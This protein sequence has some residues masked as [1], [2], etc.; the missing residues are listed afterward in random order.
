M[1]TGLKIAFVVFAGLVIVFVLIFLGILPGRRQP[2]PPEVTLEFWGF[3]DP[4]PVWLSLISSY[5]EENTH[6]DI[7]YTEIDEET[8]E[9]TLVNK[10]AEGKGPDIF[11]LKNAWIE[12]HR[13]K[14]YPLP[15]DIFVFYP[16]DFRRIFVDIA[17]QD[18]IT[19]GDD[20]IG[21]PLFVDTPALFYNKDV[22]NSHGIA[23]PPTTWDDVVLTSKTLTELTPV[24]DVVRGG[25][26]LGSATNIERVL[27]VL[28]SL[29]FQSGDAIIQ[30]D[31]VDLSQSG[32][33]ALIFYTSFADPTKSH[34]SWNIRLKNSHDALAEGSAAMTIGLARDIGTI[35]AKNPHLNLGVTKLPQQAGARNHVVYGSY[36]FPTVSNASR[37]PEEAWAF[38]SYVGS[39]G[40]SKSYTGASG[41]VP[42]RRDLLEEGTPSPELD[43]FYS[44]ALIARSWAV[45][46]EKATESLIR[47]MVESVILKTATANRALNTFKQKLQLIMAR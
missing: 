31:E 32:E 27:E 21:M 42:A 4:E 43:V 44:Q 35:R 46:D 2:P 45:P 19:E 5:T 29:I 9:E 18:L 38:L 11:M 30:G 34:Y 3:G 14:I 15:Q 7:N 6:V 1:N 40:A 22:F 23:L 33:N 16:K 12:K 8:Y 47:D 13:D 28:S 37:A 20:I 10:L 17:S 25:I 39:Q 36:V 26:A 41:R 24:G